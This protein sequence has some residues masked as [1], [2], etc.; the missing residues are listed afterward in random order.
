MSDPLSLVID[1][2]TGS[3]DAVAIMLAALTPDVSIR[4]V[5]TVAGNVPID[6]GTVNAQATLELCGCAD[7]P[8]HVGIESPLMRPLETAE[9]VH[10]PNGMG[11]VELPKPASPV[12][13]LHAVDALRQIARTEPGRHTLI[14]LGPL[15]NLAA[16]IV[17]EPN[18]LLGFRS[19]VTMGG[20]F[21]AVG[22]VHRAGEFNIWADP[23]AAK[24][25]IDAPG[26]ITFV[27]WDI[28]RRY[29]VMKPDEQAALRALGPLG[30]FAVDINCYVDQFARNEIGLAGY[31]L[32]D[33]IAMAVAIDPAVALET[34]RV[35]VD[36]GLDEASRG[37]TFVDRRLVAPEPNATIV[38]VADEPRF[39]AMLTE[40][41]RQN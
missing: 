22:N 40:A 34:E 9:N 41:C 25:V 27:G 15:T 33:P 4:A 16:A 7:V 29:A 3:D 5:T 8:V 18:L 6:Q 23:E 14:T 17:L 13:P 37:G 10:G 11:G 38:T 26:E 12:N 2:D 24:I 28:S 19:V 20:A 21:D 31:D 36:I 30:D 32:P 39:K 35:H 1:T